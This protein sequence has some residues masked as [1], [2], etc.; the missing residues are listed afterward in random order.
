MRSYISEFMRMYTNLSAQRI[1]VNL[2]E[3]F[4]MVKFHGVMLCACRWSRL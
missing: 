2:I 4:C 1:V 3:Y